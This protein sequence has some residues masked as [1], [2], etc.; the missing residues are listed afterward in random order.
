[1]D[2]IGGRRILFVSML[3]AAGCAAGFAAV[4]RSTDEDPSTAAC[5]AI[6]ALASGFN[7]CTTA[8]WNAIDLM[9]TES[10]PTDVR[11][12]GM[13]ML[14]A[15]GRAGSVLAQLV[16]GYLV[17]PPV[18]ITLL[19]TITSCLMLLGSVSSFLVTD[20]SGKSLPGSIEDMKKQQQQPEKAS[21]LVATARKQ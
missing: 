4:N 15:S 6:I 18:H 11:T 1:M 21:E 19:L 17:G 14:A 16:N 10:F 7:A 20:Y 2:V 9:S 8:G 12:T 13:G 3:L 5:V